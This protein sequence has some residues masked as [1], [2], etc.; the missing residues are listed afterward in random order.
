MNTHTPGPLEV[1]NGEIHGYVRTVAA[2]RFGNHDPICC[3][4]QEDAPLIASSYTL[5]DKAA[6]SLNVDASELAESID[7]AGL[8][9][10]AR[11]VLDHVDNGI[12]FDGTPRNRERASVDALRAALSSLPRETVKP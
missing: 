5:V 8:I 12:P 9:R 7:L 4:S 10:A 3:A 11:Q 1:K 6:R 2:D